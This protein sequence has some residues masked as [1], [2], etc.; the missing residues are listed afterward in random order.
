MGLGQTAAIKKIAVEHSQ[1]ACFSI[2][3]VFPPSAA[4]KTPRGPLKS[5]TY[6][7]K[8]ISDASSRGR[9]RPNKKKPQ[10]KTVAGA[11]VT[12]A[13]KKTGFPFGAV[14]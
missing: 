1:M 6:P 2:M 14:Q 11:A 12:S 3:P 13:S 9:K 7:P 10:K 4:H 5:S 8:P